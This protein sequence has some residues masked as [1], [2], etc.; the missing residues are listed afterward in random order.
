MSAAQGFQ[1]A[2]DAL[3]A[4]EARLTTEQKNKVKADVAA[5]KPVQ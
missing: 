4:L 5:W 2:R 3:P 1:A